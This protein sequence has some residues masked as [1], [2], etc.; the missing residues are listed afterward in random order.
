MKSVQEYVFNHRDDFQDPTRVGDP[1]R[2]ELHWHGLR[3]SFA[4]NMYSELRAS[5]IDDHE[6]RH[7][8]SEALGHSRESITFTYV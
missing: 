6:A 5:G 3:H 1:T 2:T 8:V 7:Q 4:Q